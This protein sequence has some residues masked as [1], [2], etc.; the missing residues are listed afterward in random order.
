ME[1]QELLSLIEIAIILFTAIFTAITYFKNK[2]DDLKNKAVI[3]VNQIK[4][5]EHNIENLRD[6][7]AKENLVWAGEFYKSQLVFD[8]NY[9]NKSKSLL[10]KKISND[11]YNQIEEF[12]SIATTISREQKIIKEEFCRL[13]EIK[14]KSYYEKQIEIQCKIVEDNYN[15]EKLLN[16]NLEE[17]KQ[18]IKK[19][20]NYPIDEF[21]PFINNDIIQSQLRKYTRISNTP[22]YEK[23]KKIAKIK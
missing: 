12:Y 10:M 23:I 6:N 18:K 20:F 5:I 8:E 11:Y 16:Q 9:W 15:D 14:Q 22:V 4:E 3:I 1:I 2:N 7:A 21:I 17:E 13:I 19:A